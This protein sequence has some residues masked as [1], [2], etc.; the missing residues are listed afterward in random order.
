MH[1]LISATVESSDR[2]HTSFGNRDDSDGA[3]K[4]GGI[5]VLLVEKVTIRAN[6]CTPASVRELPKT[7][8]CIII[9]DRS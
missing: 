8:Y 4:C 2:I 1:S 7:R 6:A 5:L 9:I 3:N